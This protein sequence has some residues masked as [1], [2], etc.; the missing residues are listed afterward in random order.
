MKGLSRGSARTV[1]EARE[2]DRSRIMQGLQ[3]HSNNFSSRAMGRQGGVLNTVRG[4][5]SCTRNLNYF[6]NFAIAI[7]IQY[8]NRLSTELG[9]A[10]FRIN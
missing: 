3:N 6:R 7:I 1:H 10:F 8:W 9:G 2:A 4:D 5:C